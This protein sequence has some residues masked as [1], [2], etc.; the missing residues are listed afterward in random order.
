MIYFGICNCG[1]CCDL[2]LIHD[3]C[4]TGLAAGRLKN[5]CHNFRKERMCKRIVHYYAATH[6]GTTYTLNESTREVYR[7]RDNG[8]NEECPFV[9]YGSPITYWWTPDAT[10]RAL[11]VTR[12]SAA[13]CLPDTGI[14]HTLSLHIQ[15]FKWVKGKARPWIDPCTTTPATQSEDCSALYVWARPVVC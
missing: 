9:Q 2:G 1:D 13:T 4:P 7:A 14:K 11:I 15:A 12:M 3:G 6:D 10:E 8:E 5:L